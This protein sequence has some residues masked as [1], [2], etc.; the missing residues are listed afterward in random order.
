VPERATR[1]LWAYVLSVLLAVLVLGA[2]GTRAAS[3]DVC[4]GGAPYEAAGSAARLVGSVPFLGSPRWS[5]EVLPQWSETT[6]SDNWG[7][8]VA[9]AWYQDATLW[10]AT[11]TAA[12]W[13]IPG[14][15]CGIAPGQEGQGEA[16]EQ[17]GDPYQPLVCV[18]VYAQLALA[19]FDCADAAEASHPGPP[20]T[21]ER[22]GQRLV[23]GFA[24]SGSGSVEVRFQHGSA[25]FP[26]GGGVY[27]GSASARLGK[28]VSVTELS[29]AARRPLVSVVLVDQTGAYSRSQGPLASTAHLRQ[30]AREIHARIR[31]AAPL[32]LGTAV[33]G[34]RPHDEVLFAGGARSLASRVAHALHAG[35][36]RALGGGALAMF[37]SVARVVVLVG[38]SAA[39]R[40]R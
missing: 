19:S 32:I 30:L 1:P 8:L 12:W 34:H 11:S 17:A 37:G 2:V 5:K 13:V 33:S 39:Q 9:Y 4:T 23:A 27:G 14:L 40:A 15:A 18:L 21:V 26:A 3:A 16:I 24:R 28:V 36:P 38:H 25:T 29:T 35:A 6:A 20:V 7:S 31:S 22:G 10:E